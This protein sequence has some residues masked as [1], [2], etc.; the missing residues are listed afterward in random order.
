VEPWD[1]KITKQ[2][3]T[4]KDYPITESMNGSFNSSIL[5][6]KNFKKKI[7]DNSVSIGG[8]EHNLSD[9]HTFILSKKSFS[10]QKIYSE[11]E[12]S[13]NISANDSLSK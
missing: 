9:L 7:Y 5:L 8:T 6:E 13:G 4:L 3:H 11:R 1:G 12:I 10:D 2:N